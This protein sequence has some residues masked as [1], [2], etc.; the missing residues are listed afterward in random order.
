MRSKSLPRAGQR[1]R[2]IVVGARVYFESENSKQ[3]ADRWLGKVRKSV[4]AAQAVEHRSRGTIADPDDLSACLAGKKSFETSLACHCPVW[5]NYLAMNGLCRVVK[6]YHRS[7]RF[8]SVLE[9]ANGGSAPS[10]GTKLRNTGPTGS[11]QLGSARQKPVRI[12][13]GLEMWLSSPPNLGWLTKVLVPPSYLRTPTQDC[14]GPSSRAGAD[15]SAMMSFC[16]NV[17]LGSIAAVAAT[18]RLFLFLL[19]PTAPQWRDQNDKMRYLIGERG[20]T[21][22]ADHPSREVVSAC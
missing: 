11:F 13:W 22:E 5:I 1:Q 15:S 16:E 8:W 9:G 14:M 2:C 4:A 3:Y 12:S 7:W 6:S 10:K 17:S 19:P 20:E 21:G 18:P